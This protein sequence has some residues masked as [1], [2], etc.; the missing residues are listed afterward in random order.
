MEPDW[1]PL[2]SNPETFNPL[3]QRLGL[4]PEYTFTDL[5]GL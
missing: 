4:P 5:L 3:A 1:K 2:E